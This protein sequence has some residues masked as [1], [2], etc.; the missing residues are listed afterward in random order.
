MHSYWLIDRHFKVKFWIDNWLGYCI[1]D[2]THAPKHILDILDCRESDYFVDGTWHFTGYF[3][4]Q[5]LDILLVLHTP[6]Y[7]HDCRL[8]PNSAVGVLTSKRSYEMLR[9]PL[10]KM[11]CAP[12]IWSPFIPQLRSAIVWCAVWGKLP[13]SDIIQR[14]CYASP[15]VCLTT[16]E[17][18]EHLLTECR[19][20]RSII[21]LSLTYL[22]YT[23]AMI[24]GSL[25]CSYM[26]NRFTRVSKSVTYGGWHL[27][28]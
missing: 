26:H 4:T 3:L 23:F 17:F 22:I 2:R 27:S 14:I 15:T 20:T 21:L 5:L 7:D 6:V 10:L 13:T 25:V 12:W 11:P 24:W 28:P 19:F 1:V 8:W 9:S 18:Q 16:S